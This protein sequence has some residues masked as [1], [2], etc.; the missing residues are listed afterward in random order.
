MQVCTSLQTDNHASTSPLGF[1]QAG[2]PSCRPTNSVRALKALI[3]HKVQYKNKSK[4]KLQ[5]LH[6]MM[7]NIKVERLKCY[8]SKKIKTEKLRNTNMLFILMYDHWWLMLCQS[9]GER[10]WSLALCGLRGVMRSWSDFWFLCCIYCLLVC[11]VC[12]PTYPFLF[13]FSLLISSLNHLFLLRIDLLH[14]QA[15]SCK[16]DQTWL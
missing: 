11:I 5:L 6:C 12:F 1:L 8:R 3:V 9:T 16:S 10:C 4:C 13:T 7:L 14:F 2:C 15:W